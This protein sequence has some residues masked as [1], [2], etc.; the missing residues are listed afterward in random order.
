MP[1]TFLIYQSS[2]TFFFKYIFLITS[3]KWNITSFLW[4]FRNFFI[5]IFK[6]DFLNKLLF[7]KIVS[8]LDGS[9]PIKPLLKEETNQSQLETFRLENES[10]QLWIKIPPS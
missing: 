8:H 7:L 1:N 5:F 9:S 6:T 2:Q 4:I 10:Y 3:V